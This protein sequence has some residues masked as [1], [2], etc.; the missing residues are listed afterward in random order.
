MNITTTRVSPLENDNSIVP[1]RGRQCADF[2]SAIF[3]WIAITANW[4]S[5][6]G[7]GASKGLLRGQRVLGTRTKAIGLWKRWTHTMGLAKGWAH[8]DRAIQAH[9]CNSPA[10]PFPP[11]GGGSRWG[12]GWDRYFFRV[13][14]LKVVFNTK[15]QMNISIFTLPAILSVFIEK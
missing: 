2:G 1:S 6:H 14:S 5:A 4:W 12:A 11:Y 7:H 8:G 10:P 3:R 9:A 13:M 15:I